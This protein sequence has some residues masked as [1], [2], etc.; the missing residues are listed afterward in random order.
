MAPT[1]KHPLYPAM[2]TE[3]L[4]SGQNDSWDFFQLE[5]SDGKV[6]KL[7][8]ANSQVP[9]HVEE[10]NLQQENEVNI[11]EKKKTVRDSL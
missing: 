9:H 3:C 10:A 2:V 5:F 4:R 1:T 6:E 11:T 8:T 7:T